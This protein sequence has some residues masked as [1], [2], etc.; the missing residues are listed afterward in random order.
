MEKVVELQK[1]WLE[2]KS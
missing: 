1:V 2:S